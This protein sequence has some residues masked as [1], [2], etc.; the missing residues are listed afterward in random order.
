M[1]PPTPADFQA[2]TSDMLKLIAGGGDI[3]R[4]IKDKVDNSEVWSATDF[5]SGIE[6]EELKAKL[7][8]SAAAGGSGASCDA[9]YYKYIKNVSKLH[10]QREQL[11]EY[12]SFIKFDDKTYGAQTAKNSKNLHQMKALYTSQYTVLVDFWINRM[13]IIYYVILFIYIGILVKNRKYRSKIHI[14]IAIFLGVYPL[15]INRIMIWLL[16]IME[17]LFQY[18]PANAYRNL[19]NQNINKLE[20]NDIYLHYTQMPV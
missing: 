19:Y 15:V 18:T 17:Y 12:L 10:H 4:W 20:K 5:L 11:K 3:H 6:R 2:M 13:R 8:A 14:A 7:D 16:S 9:D 1:A